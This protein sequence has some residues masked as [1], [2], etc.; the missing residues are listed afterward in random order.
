MS[1]PQL[2]EHSFATFTGQHPLCL[3]YFSGPDCAVCEQLKPK[4][5]QTLSGEL[6]H[7]QTAQVDC[8]AQR[9]LAAS[10]RVFTIPTLVVFIEGRESQRFVRSFSPADVARKLL[11]PYQL[12]YES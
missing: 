2:D 10:H 6:P 3:V 7:L 12:C 11:R 5:I 8:N 4:L 1:L 9:A